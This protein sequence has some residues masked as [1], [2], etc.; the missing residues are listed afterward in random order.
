MTSILL[1]LIFIAIMLWTLSKQCYAQTILLFLAGI[2]IFIW[3][4][5]TGNS[6][7]GA[8]TCG[9]NFLDIF[10]YMRGQT[11]SAFSGI[12]ITICA[13]MGY[14]S[15]MS[16]TKSAQML[17][18][19]A[20]I[21]LKKFKSPYVCAALAIIIGTLIK[22]G[23]PS[24]SSVAAITLATL[25]PVLMAVGLPKKSA[26]AAIM[27]G[28][29]VSFGPADFSQ[30][31]IL[32]LIAPEWSIP[33]T[34]VAF[35]I[36]VLTW[37]TLIFAVTA[38]IWMSIVDKKEGEAPEADA[39][40]ELKP[41]AV[42]C[43]VWYGIFPILPVIL[44]VIF[45]EAVI[46]TIS[47]TVEACCFMCM[48]LMMIIEIIRKGIKLWRNTLN[49][50]K[51]FFVNMGVN[52]TN[53]VMLTAAATT[54]AGAI[55]KMG[56][57][58]VLAKIVVDLGVPAI[59]SFGLIVVFLEVIVFA[60]GSPT[61]AQTTMAPA[62]MELAGRYGFEPVRISLLSSAGAGF[63]RHFSPVAGITILVMGTTGV[64]I[65]QL[66]KRE[67]VPTIISLLALLVLTFVI[68]L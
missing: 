49:E 43:P 55:G 47:I 35:Q 36:P 45:S 30:A 19:L 44:V 20:C 9:N 14:S 60:T 27:M 38:A 12:G 64:T 68:L 29:S 40:T 34:F 54:C 25:Y 33:Q 10:E 4:I 39:M 56:G 52:L 57:F 26:A 58:A 41:S 50:T 53:V 67:F 31:S 8:N 5:A 11:I 15:Y 22:M 62:M 42:G 48:F 2:A 17:A 7:M 21:P 51:I 63:A 13:A 61:G 59:I 46:G 66:I 23:V 28:T 32:P 24:A 65:G 37:V 1:T 6:I 3:Q 18:A 16:H